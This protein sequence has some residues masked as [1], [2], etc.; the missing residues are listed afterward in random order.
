MIT[1]CVRELNAVLFETEIS[2]EAFKRIKRKPLC[3][4]NCLLG[5]V[6]EATRI[7]GFL[8]KQFPDLL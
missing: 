2:H 4:E 6:D 1:Y 7:G 8:Q 5:A 3:D